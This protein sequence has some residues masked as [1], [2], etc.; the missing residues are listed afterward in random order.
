MMVS[1][2]ASSPVQLPLGHLYDPH[3]LDNDQRDQFFVSHLGQ[4]MPAFHNPG[5]KGLTDETA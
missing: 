1:L 5:Q 4:R 2:L 3:R